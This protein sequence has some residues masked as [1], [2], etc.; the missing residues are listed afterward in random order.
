MDKTFWTRVLLAA[1]V[2]AM[3]PF[4]ARAYDLMAL[5]ESRYVAGTDT[6]YTTYYNDNRSSING[7]FTDHGVAAWLPC[8]VNSLHGPNGEIPYTGSASYPDVPPG[9]WVTPTRFGHGYPTP[10]NFTCAQPASSLPLYRLYKGA[11]QTDHV[12]TTSASEV[13]TLEASG[14]AFDRVDGYVFTTQVN[15]TVPFYRL[16]K[17]TGSDTEHRYTISAS[18]RTTLLNAGWTQDT[19]TAYVFPTYVNP[20]VASTSFTGTFN[21]LNVNPTTIT[22]VPIRNLVPPTTS[23]T[24]GGNATTIQYGTMASNVTVRPGGAVW[25]NLTFDF[26]TGDLFPPSGG[27]NVN[28]IPFFLHYAS[29][30]NKI[31][32]SGVP[33]YDGIAMVLVPGNTLNGVTCPG[34]P[35]NGGQVFIEIGEAVSIQCASV[36]SALQNNTWYTLSYS[37][38]DSAS[39]RI[40][41]TNRG[42]GVPLTFVGGGTTFTNTYAS[43]YSCPLSA[44]NSYCTNPYKPQGY[45]STNTGYM[46]TY[47]PQT[48][49]DIT[50]RVQ[51]LKAQWLDAS[52]NPL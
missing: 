42:S 51:N 13:T 24:L 12:Y 50:A 44:D 34:A 36:T 41:V 23:L 22:N 14:Y 25:Q 8:S 49:A 52:L 45:P 21:G 43:L 35:A 32:L 10:M 7:G 33:P 47:I 37:L 46:Y 17:T 28:H 39:V 26:Y 5:W 2:V 18:A 38:N 6:F 4:H 9:D 11:P 20:L 29:Q 3:W 31:I 40:N 19:F 16:H 48:G 30:A 27:S 1:T 15:G